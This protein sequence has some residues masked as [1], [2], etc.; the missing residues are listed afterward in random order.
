[1]ACVSGSSNRPAPFGSGGV[2]TTSSGLGMFASFF[3][4]SSSVMRVVGTNFT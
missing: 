2:N 1:M 4:S 3:C